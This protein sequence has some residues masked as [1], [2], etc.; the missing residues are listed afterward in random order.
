M[1]H[2]FLYYLGWYLITLFSRQGFN[3]KEIAQRRNQHSQDA[4]DAANLFVPASF[5]T[6]CPARHYRRP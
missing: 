5:Q 1:I 2:L 3:D 4:H 6:M